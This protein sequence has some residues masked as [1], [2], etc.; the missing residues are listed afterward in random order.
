MGRMRR[1]LLSAIP[2]MVAGGAWAQEARPVTLEYSHREPI[3]ESVWRV[4]DE[5]VIDRKVAE[6]LG[7]TVRFVDGEADIEAEGRR[8][9]VPLRQKPIPDGIPLMPALG[10]LGAYS[11]WIEDNQLRV[12][13]AVRSIVFE[14]GVLRIDSTITFAPSLF[15]LANPGRLAID[16]HG[17]RIPDGANF[18][19]P[20]E[21]RVVQQSH[22]V[23][24]ITLEHPIVEELFVPGAVSGRKFEITI[25][26]LTGSGGTSSATP[27]VG[28]FTPLQQGEPSDVGTSNSSAPRGVYANL[29]NVV[30]TSEAVESLWI[31]H[32]G[33]IGEGVKASY[34]SP[35]TI[36]VEIPGTTV[37]NELPTMPE[38]ESIAGISWSTAP[39][40]NAVVTLQLARPCGYSVK[41]SGTK[42]QIQLLRPKN[43]NGRLAGKTIVL[44]AGHGGND[45]GAQ[46]PAE[47]VQEKTLTLKV[48]KHLQAQLQ[49]E[50]AKVIL[51]RFDDTFI[52]LKERPA[53]AT[54][55]K[56]DIFV[57]VHFNS[58]KNANSSS[59][60][61]SFFHGQDPI[62]R[63]L[64]EC[65]QTELGKMGRLPKIGTWSDTRIYQSGFAVLRNATMPAV[66]LELG[67]I[68]NKKD[69]QEIVRTEFH[70]EAAAAIIK[71][72][73]VFFADGK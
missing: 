57:S 12:D 30:K 59:G 49:A 34:D 11:E 64:A 52:S 73:K 17:A 42:V 48:V 6:K 19:L 9:R 72:L 71:G 25:G 41:G 31:G 53:I 70:V 68:N 54:R 47:G 55:A 2:W 28:Q 5:C 27:N 58:N 1:I 61:I 14:N 24:R 65:I 40:G 18:G 7:W 46:W 51:T 26:A 60:I 43:S 4:G 35:L 63:L 21:F 69:R 3:K 62:S 38:S 50:G 39:N 20:K 44:D 8:L 32:S 36:A 22:S 67:F 33:P 66:L 13:G 10:Q 29:L 16:L 37:A 56:A 15:K 45:G 23:V